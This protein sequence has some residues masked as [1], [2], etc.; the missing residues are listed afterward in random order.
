MS[1]K[2]SPYCHH[3]SSASPIFIIGTE[4]SG[5]NLLRLVLN[6][7]PAITVPHPPHIMAYF[8]PLEKHYGDLA[9]ADNFSRL[10]DDVITH[11]QRHI[12]PWPTPLDKPWLLRSAQPQDLFGLF[13]AI[14]EQHLASAGKRRWGCKSTFMIHYVDRILGSYPDARLIWLVRDPRDVALSSRESVFN[15]FHPYYVARLWTSQQRLGLALESKL[16]SANLM[17]VYY[18]DLISNA[19]DIVKQIC[20]F[21][22]EDFNPAMLRFFETEEARVSAH[23]ARDW[24][25][26]TM[27]ILTG[28]AHKY[29][30]SMHA[31]EIAI[32][33]SE[34][35]EIMNRLGYRLVSTSRAVQK[36]SAV[37][38]LRYRFVNEWLR[39]KV[40]YRSVR[41]DR[42][43]GRRWARHMRMISL[44]VRLSLGLR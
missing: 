42:N 7:H 32:V 12:Y 25:Q 15:P 16:T 23:L 34:A 35:G 20:N 27:P 4:R 5:S 30:H 2:G 11:V 43:Q 40:E 13:T 33:E 24:R 3:V 18:E 9:K 17:R 8:A 28:N 19:E 10:T 22:G 39:L 14:Y 31:D 38:R 44:K 26:T 29:I 41:E 37:Q 36:S 6:A 1:D 21:A